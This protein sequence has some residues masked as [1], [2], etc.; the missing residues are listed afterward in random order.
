MIIWPAKAPTEVEDFEF[1]FSDLLETGESLTS[2]AFLLDGVTKDS[3]AF[4]NGN[5]AV[6]VWLSAGT[7]GSVAKVTCTVTTSNGRTYTEVGV[8]PINGTVVSLA[9]AKAAQKIEVADEDLLLAGFLRAAIGAVEAAT[10]KNLTEKIESQTADGF[11]L[12]D[13]A[14]R[15]WRGPVSQI[16][17][18][19]YDDA[20]GVEQT[21]SSFRLVEGRDAKLLPAYG[22]S[23]PVTAKGPGTVRIT[24]VAG[25]DPAELPAELTQAALLLFG[26]FNANREAVIASDRAAAV[27]LPLGVAALLDP[28]R[29]PGIA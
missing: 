24:Y 13:K 10:S 29:A 1:D 2:K 23:W 19:K 7:A 20:D 11:P 15:L 6:Q 14:I 25:Y 3:D 17:S 22:A 26:H 12:C 9:T 16:L 5:T 18:V 21:L 27:E 4:V 8:L 28:Y